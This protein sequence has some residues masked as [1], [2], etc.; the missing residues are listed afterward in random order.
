[1]STA[2]LERLLQNLEFLW[3]EGCLQSNIEPGPAF[4]PGIGGAAAVR[5]VHGCGLGQVAEYSRRRVSWI[6][7]APRR[8]QR[9]GQIPLAECQQGVVS[10]VQTWRP[11]QDSNLRSRLRR[12]VLYPL[13][14]GGMPQVSLPVPTTHA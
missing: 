14:Y 13:S 12:A 7:F 10:P 3:G 6:Q 2:L 4:S 5:G 9:N 1:M 8:V 11:R